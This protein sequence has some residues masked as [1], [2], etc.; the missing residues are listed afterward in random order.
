MDLTEKPVLDIERKREYIRIV[1]R[2]LKDCRLTKEFKDYVNTTEFINFSKN[3]TKKNE[4]YTEV[5][6]DRDCCARILGCCN[7]INYLYHNGRKNT[8]NPY[9]LLLCYLALFNEDEFKRY[10]SLPPKSAEYSKPP[11]P[12]EFVYGKLAEPDGNAP[13]WRG[14]E[15][16]DKDRELVRKWIKIKEAI[17]GDKN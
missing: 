11:N 17:Y 15:F 2:V 1:M 8:Y 13:A 12:M 10:Y 16:G 14:Y 4:G 3:F 5:W 9:N 6:Y 7:F